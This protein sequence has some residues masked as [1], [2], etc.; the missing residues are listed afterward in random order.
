V[1][2]LYSAGLADPTFALMQNNLRRASFRNDRVNFLRD[3]EEEARSPS[4]FEW[5]EQ[6]VRTP[7]LKV[8][9]KTKPGALTRLFRRFTHKN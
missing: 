9:I 7:V 1:H 3:E 6:T 2:V 4:Y 5:R 8:E